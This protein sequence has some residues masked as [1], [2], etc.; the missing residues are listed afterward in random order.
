MSSVRRPR[1][2]ILRSVRDKRSVKLSNIVSRLGWKRLVAAA[3]Q[4]QNFATVYHEAVFVV[5]QRLELRSRNA[6]LLLF[7]TGQLSTQLLCPFLLYLPLS[8]TPS[9][10][11]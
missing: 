4:L 2:L 3:T 9:A 7:L 8:P 10:S 11:R 6:I 1:P 5:M